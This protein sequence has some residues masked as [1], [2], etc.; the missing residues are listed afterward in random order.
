MDVRVASQ[1]GLEIKDFRAFRNF[2]LHN[3]QCQTNDHDTIV[4]LELR[5]MT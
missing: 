3:F 4:V 2:Q 1:A 5:W